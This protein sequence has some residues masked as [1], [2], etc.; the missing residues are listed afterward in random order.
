MAKRPSIR[1][2]ITDHRSRVLALAENVIIL[3]RS[4]RWST[5]ADGAV[6][7]GAEGGL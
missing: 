4:T 7:A 6:G 5:T 2:R 3:D 1:W